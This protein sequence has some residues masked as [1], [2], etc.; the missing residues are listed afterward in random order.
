MTLLAWVLFLGLLTLLFG[1][2]LDRQLNPNQ[3]VMSRAVPGGVEVVLDR[4]R[5]GHYVATARINGVPVEV[6]VDTGASHVSVPARIAE[7]TG[8]E[9][10]AAMAV[11]TANGTV[12]V[13]ATWI[14]RI[15]LGELSLS[16]V[17]AS[18]NPHMDED[19]VLLGMSFLKDL[20][21]TQRRDQLILRQ[22]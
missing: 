8:L 7:R 16:G 21:F 4:N 14:D 13:Y 10:G 12:P 19:F 1:D 15:Q 22:Q 17:R 11:S 2:L 3:E 20:E 9:P 5:A 18:I 6:I